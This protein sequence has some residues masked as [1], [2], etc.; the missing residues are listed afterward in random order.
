[1]TKKDIFNKYGIEYKNGKIN[2]PLGWLPL[3]LKDGNAKTGK[4][5]KTWSMNTTTCAVHCEGCYGE[6]GCY[7]F[8]GVKRSLANNTELARN[9]PDFTERALIAQLETMPDGTEIRIHAVGDFF[10]LEY[11]QMWQ[12][13]VE[14]FNNLVFWTY[15]KTE[16]ADAFDGFANANIV[17][18]IAHGK[19]NF[20]HCDHVMALYEELQ[21]AGE[22]VHICKCGVDP[23]QHC[24]GCHKCS[25]SDYVLFL[26]H[27][28]E[29]DAESDPLYKAFCEMVNNQ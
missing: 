6:R 11:V 22:S 27:S 8:S 20:G 24:A 28:T 2:T 14:R 25:I 16:Y 15:T 5:V 13:I 18:S 9:F 23:E 19:L 26:E 7:N 3:L 1:M 21:T 10:S 17:K 12:R 4:S 29:Y